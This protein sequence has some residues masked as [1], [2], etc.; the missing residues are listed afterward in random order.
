[1]S[2]M[3]RLLICIYFPQFKS[4][5]KSRFESFFVS[6]IKKEN[7]LSKKK[8]IMKSKNIY[9]DRIVSNEDKRTRLMIKGIPSNIS[10]KEVRNIIEQYGNLNYLYIT[11]DQKDEEENTSIVYLNVINYKSIIP[12]FMN[13]RHYKFIINE[14]IY[15][16]K[17]MYSIA[18]GK[19]QLKEYIKKN[20]HYKYFD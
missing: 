8:N 17:I 11:K 6:I 19:N 7:P 14:R 18:Q 9:P 5:N 20:H 1:M 4:P 3:E 15:N 2:F 13:L 16:I 12:L 10:K